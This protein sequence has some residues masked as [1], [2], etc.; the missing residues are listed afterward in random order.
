MGR[1]RKVY[2]YINLVGNPATETGHPI[3]FPG[4]LGPNAKPHTLTYAAVLCS[5]HKGEILKEAY[6]LFA[7][8]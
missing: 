6:C 7:S 1:R 8:T 2:K 3:P 5:P 4:D